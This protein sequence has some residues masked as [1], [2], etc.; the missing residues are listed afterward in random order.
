VVYSGQA[1]YLK[2]HWS[3]LATHTYIFRVDLNLSV[4]F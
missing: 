1:C 4:S 2:T 3:F